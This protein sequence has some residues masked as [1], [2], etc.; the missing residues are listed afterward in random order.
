MTSIHTIISPT[1]FY[2]L[3]SAQKKLKVAEEV[4]KSTIL[5]ANEDTENERNE[6]ETENTESKDKHNTKTK[7]GK[8]KPSSE[9]N[10][11]PTEKAMQRAA[12]IIEMLKD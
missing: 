12:D 9:K 4:N 2:C 6:S 10:D 5:H 1:F 8:L 7:K 11:L 3:E